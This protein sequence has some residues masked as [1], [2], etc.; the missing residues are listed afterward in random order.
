MNRRVFLVTAAASVTR[1]TAQTPEVP[2]VIRELKP[3]TDGIQPITDDERHARIEKAR[4]L[5]R[6]NKI[7]AIVLEGGSSM[8]YFTGTRWAASERTFGVVIPAQRRAGVDRSRAERRARA[9]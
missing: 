1:M 5:M 8:F 4:R 3:M 2:A 7:D 9:R 6:E